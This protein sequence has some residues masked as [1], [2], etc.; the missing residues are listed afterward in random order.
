MLSQSLARGFRLVLV[1]TLGECRSIFD[2]PAPHYAI[3][4]ESKLPRALSPS[5][6]KLEWWEPVLTA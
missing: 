2:N 5:A 3:G 4:E 1:T 6:H